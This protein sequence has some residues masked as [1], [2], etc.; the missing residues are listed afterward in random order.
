MPFRIYCRVYAQPYNYTSDASHLGVPI[1]LKT[2]GPDDNVSRESVKKVYLQ[3]LAD[4][5]TSCRLFQGHLK[6]SWKYINAYFT[7]RSTHYIRESICIWK[8]GI[9]P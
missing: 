5:G 8:I 3:I 2:P 6:S 4:F 1:L 9:T 7:S